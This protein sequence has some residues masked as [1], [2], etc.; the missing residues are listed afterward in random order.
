MKK[1]VLISLMGSALWIG[2]SKTSKEALLP[3]AR[4]DVA[5]YAD[6]LFEAL[7]EGNIET[8][9][10]LLDQGQD[11]NLQD[12]YGYTLLHRAAE[13]GDIAM[14]ELLLETYKAK[15][16]VK[17]AEGKTP[18]HRVAEGYVVDE[19][20]MEPVVHKGHV[21]V[22]QLL[23][24]KGAQVDAQDEEQKTPLHYAT[25]FGFTQIIEVLIARGA[26]VNAQDMYGCTALHIAVQNISDDD[27]GVVKLLL[28]H[29]DIGPN[30]QNLQ[31]SYKCTALHMASAKGNEALVTL[32]LNHPK[33]APSLTAQNIRNETPL[34]M[35]SKNGHLAVAVALFKKVVVNLPQAGALGLAGLDY[36]DAAG[37]TL[38]HY[39]ACYGYVGL[40]S[41]ACKKYGIDLFHAQDNHGISPLQYALYNNHQNFSSAVL[42][43]YQPVHCQDES[44]VATAEIGG[45]ASAPV[46]QPLRPRNPYMQLEG[47]M[48][49]PI[50][51]QE[52]GQVP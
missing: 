30:L 44:M 21:A 17:D 52:L 48:H 35:A 6:A 22:T 29:S 15:V 14:A 50:D 10:T 24:D 28:S 31:T 37:R 39:A 11:P 51:R 33:I 34:Y 38:L 20:S 5:N 26:E 19:A 3:Q 2:C 45:H 40:A 25:N 1:I 18:L 41:I 12:G 49:A 27:L 7:E 46:Q 9:K 16:D 42:D 23:I 32:L 13:K 36:K 43:N 8:V 47:G 4:V